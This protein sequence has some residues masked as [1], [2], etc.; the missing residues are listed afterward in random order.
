MSGKPI[1]P[2]SL[3]QDTW[4]TATG[5]EDDLPLIFRFRQHIPVAVHRSADFSTLI[6][7]YWR[8]DGTAN[9]GMPPSEDNEHQIEFE[10]AMAPIDEQDGLGY[11]MLVV[12]G[13]SRKEWIFYTNDVSVWLDRFNEILVGHAVYPVEIETS[14]DPNW[15]TWKGVAVCAQH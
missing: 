14:T 11:L 12:T 7:I 13:N 9:N 2:D 4:A 1:V 5:R 3:S 8:Y 15:S 6:N 10:D